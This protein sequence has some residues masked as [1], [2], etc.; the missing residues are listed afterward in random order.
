MRISLVFL[1][2]TVASLLEAQT[3]GVNMQEDAS[4]IHATVKDAVYLIRQDY[5][6]RDTTD[7]ARRPMG[8]NR[9]PYFGRFYYLAMNVNGNLITDAS[10]R[11]PWMQD[12]NFSMVR[13][14]AKLLP[15]LGTTAIRRLSDTVFRNIGHRLSDTIPANIEL[16]DSSLALIPVHSQSGLL[17][18]TVADSGSDSAMWYWTLKV[19]G[20][21]ADRPYVAFDTVPSVG[22]EV[23]KGRYSP[24]TGK[25]VTKSYYASSNAIGGLVLSTHPS[26]GRM[27]FRVHGV[28]VRKPKGR[29]EFKRLK[30]GKSTPAKKL[31]ATPAPDEKPPGKVEMTSIESIE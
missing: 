27:E 13:D 10:V 31:Q 22:Y 1:F 18:D 15:E 11:T 26:L 14:S 7:P 20:P 3:I 19:R 6:I 29:F 12:P 24:G 17:P 28:I 5:H 25:Y 21:L 2:L 16:P 8:L 30:A 23:Q 4:K 9:N